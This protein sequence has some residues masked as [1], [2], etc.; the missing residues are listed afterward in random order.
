MKKII[1]ISVEA[2]NI[3]D[4]YISSFETQEISFYEYNCKLKP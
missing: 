1:D 4:K 3:V 2:K